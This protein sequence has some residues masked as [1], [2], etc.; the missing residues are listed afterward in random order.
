[1]DIKNK[2]WIALKMETGGAWEHWPTK[3]PGA[4]GIPGCIMIRKDLIRFLDYL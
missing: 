1:M 4:Y 3:F 2:V